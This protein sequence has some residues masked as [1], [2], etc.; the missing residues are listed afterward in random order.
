MQLVQSSPRS[1]FPE[2]AKAWPLIRRAFVFMWLLAGGSALA[3]AT[4]VL[5]TVTTAPT[6]PA[7]SAPFTLSLR[8]LDLTQV[9]VEDARVLA[10]F[11]RSGE[12]APV[13][14]RLE[15]TGTAGVYETTLELPQEGGYTLL[16]RDQTYRQ[17][18][19]QATL[20]FSVGRVPAQPLEFVFPPTATG[21]GV[22]T[23]IG[24]LIGLPLAVAGV[25]TALV[26]LRGGEANPA[27]LEEA[28]GVAPRPQK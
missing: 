25:V 26:I 13:S 17:E 21:S 19:A 16:L 11:R 2:Q 18:E 4:P 9:P 20:R 6:P 24:F 22:W 5:G 12:A 14:A 27:P 15:E 1:P 10:E 7:A 28:S 3:H 8:L 23:W